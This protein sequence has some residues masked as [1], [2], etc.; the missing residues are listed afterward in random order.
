[1]VL[2]KTVWYIPFYNTEYGAGY[3]SV[4]YNA[5][6]MIHDMVLIMARVSMKQWIHLHNSF[7]FLHGLFLHEISHQICFNMKQHKITHE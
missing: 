5:L 1:M 7:V 3:G 6:F 4:I 2:G